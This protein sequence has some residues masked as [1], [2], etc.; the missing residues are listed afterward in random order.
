M[1]PRTWAWAAWQPW[2]RSCALVLPDAELFPRLPRTPTPRAFCSSTT[3]CSSSCPLCSCPSPSRGTPQSRR[4]QPGDQPAAQPRRTTG[5]RHLPPRPRAARPRSS[6]PAR[7]LFD[8]RARNAAPSCHRPCCS[9]S[10]ARPARTIRSRVPR[11][12]C[13][14]RTRLGATPT[15]HACR[16]APSARRRQRRPRGRRSRR[17]GARAKARP[18]P[19]SCRHPRRLC[20]RARSRQ[21]GSCTLG[22][23]ARSC[24]H[25]HCKPDSH[26]AYRK[27][28]PC[29]P[30]ACTPPDSA[31]CCCCTTACGIGRSPM[32]SCPGQHST[33]PPRQ[34][35]TAAS[36]GPWARSC[37][38]G[39]GCARGRPRSC[40][41]GA[42]RN[43]TRG[44]AR[45]TSRSSP[46]PGS[47]PRRSRGS[48]ARPASGRWP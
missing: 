1:R 5:C 8:R 15:Q 35:R 44:T 12:R 2:E 34:T 46:C 6:G 24:G 30:D 13:G 41:T 45:G 21:P 16:C 19:R 4:Q 36:P 43:P 29:P 39:P 48:P 28:P 47:G 14:Q 20:E 25:G 31:S 40:T 9:L 18:G 17:A 11:C 23:C 37:Q 7:A 38:R 27:A 22:G 33:D 42:T 26:G 10:A 3:A 32:E